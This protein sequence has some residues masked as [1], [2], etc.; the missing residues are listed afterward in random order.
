MK[1][2]APSSR[3]ASWW[4]APSKK[5][6]VLLASVAAVIVAVAVLAVTMAASSSQTMQSW[7]KESGRKTVLLVNRD[8]QAIARDVFG[9]RD[10]VRE[11]KRLISDSQA[12]LHFPPPAGGGEYNAWLN[13]LIEQGYSAQ[14]YGPYGHQTSL[15]QDTVRRVRAFQAVCRGYGIE[16]PTGTAIPVPS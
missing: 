10:P 11:A 12:G 13:D 8:N 1:P 5:K 15:T 14:Q 7:W 4:Q 16:F 9:G 2:G 3:P 6:L